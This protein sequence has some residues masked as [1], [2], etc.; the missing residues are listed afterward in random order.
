MKKNNKLGVVSYIGIGITA[1]IVLATIGICLLDFIY[2]KGVYDD[3]SQIGP[4][5]VIFI[6]APYFIYYVIT[7]VISICI[8]LK[9][10]KSK[11]KDITIAILYGLPIVCTILL[12]LFI[13]L[14]T[15]RS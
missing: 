2:N 7:T 8:D 5:L 3:Y 6:S 9:K 10:G 4:I 1:L 11:G 12:V 14:L 15:I 13:T